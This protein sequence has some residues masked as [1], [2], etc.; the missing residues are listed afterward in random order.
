MNL[1]VFIKNINNYQRSG[2]LFYLVSCMIFCLSV[3]NEFS[4]IIWFTYRF[5]CIIDKD[6]FYF[7]DDFTVYTYF[8]L[9]Y[10]HTL[11]IW[12]VYYICYTEKTIQNRFYTYFVTLILMY[13]MHFTNIKDDMFSILFSIFL[14]VY[15]I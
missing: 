14:L 1:H 6:F 3:S 4:D 11:N 8:K 15:K 7:H 9:M 13:Y 10:F 12:N 5:E 2:I